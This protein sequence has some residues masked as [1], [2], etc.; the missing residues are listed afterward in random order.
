MKSLY[1]A[2][3]V[4]AVILQ[5]PYALPLHAGA[6]DDDLTPQEFFCRTVNEDWLE[7]ASAAILA[8]KMSGD[9]V[10]CSGSRKMLL[11]A[12]TMKALTTG[13]ALHSLGPD[14]RFETRLG[15]SGEIDRASCTETST[16]S[17]AQTRHWGRGIRSQS[18]SRPCSGNGSHFWTRPESGP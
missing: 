16:S 4:T 17:E 7:P 10:A 14:Y 9:T 2:S 11:P 15:Y 13:L 8:V 6:G 1:T 3:I 12:S 18:R 5:A